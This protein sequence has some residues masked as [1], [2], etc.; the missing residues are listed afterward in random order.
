ML[1]INLP[2]TGPTR[3]TFADFIKYRLPLPSKGVK[4]RGKDNTV[5]VFDN[6]DEAVIYADQLEE[7]VTNVSKS[8][9]ARS[10]LRD[11]VTAIRN[12]DS[13]RNYLEYSSIYTW[14]KNRVKS[15][16]MAIKPSAS[17]LK[18]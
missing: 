12:D 1:R 15:I 9:P 10:M 7:I 8:S 5:L 6:E 14:V 2:P 17:F 18:N 3:V 16:R 4:A 11:M 13:I